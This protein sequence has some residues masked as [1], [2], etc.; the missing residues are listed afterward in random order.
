ME[1]W[2]VVGY[3]A[4][5]FKDQ[6]GAQVN[7]Y[8][9][10]LARQPESKNIFGLEVHSLFISRAYVDYVPKENQMVG[11]S[12]NRYGKVADIVPCEE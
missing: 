11:I 6:S 7:G 10:Y 9:L 8:K 1:K 2:K 12:Y 4:V 3:R 5:D